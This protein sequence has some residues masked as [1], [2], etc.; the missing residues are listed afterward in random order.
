MEPLNQ[1]PPIT[2]AGQP[3]RPALSPGVGKPDT[4]SPRFWANASQ[5][6]LRFATEGELD[7]AIDWLW[8]TPE[9]RDLPRV[10]V[11]HNTI[12]VPADAVD[13]F[14]RKGFD[15]TLGKVFSAGD[16]PAEEANRIRL[17]GVS[18]RKGH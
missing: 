7:A 3:A 9:L 18:L 5:A 8:S 2:E 16:V 11:G 17:S 13:L 1:S 12:I 14:R 4:W 6:G 10:H 15:F